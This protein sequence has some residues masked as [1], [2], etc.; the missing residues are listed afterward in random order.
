MAKKSY[1]L[2]V[3]IPVVII[4]AV[5]VVVFIMCILFFVFSRNIVSDLLNDQVDNIAAQNT[6]PVSSY[7]RKAH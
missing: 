6:Q 7:L 3:R 4:A 2:S 5:T 1:K